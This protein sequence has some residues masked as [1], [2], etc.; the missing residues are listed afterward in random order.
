MNVFNINTSKKFSN[1]KLQL[2]WSTI[3]PWLVERTGHYRIVCEPNKKGSSQIINMLAR[4]ASSEE[5]SEKK[6]KSRVL[7]TTFRLIS[8]DYRIPDVIF[9]GVPDE[10]LVS[11]LLFGPLPDS[12]VQADI[13]PCLE[14]ILY[15]D[16]QVLFESYDYGR[17]QTIHITKD[18]ADEI[19]RLLEKKGLSPDIL[20]NAPAKNKSPWFFAGRVYEDQKV[21]K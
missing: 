1:E 12:S 18:E 13:A 21:R 9:H 15:R 2:C 16:E 19:R 17:F 11:I 4:H 8:K 5:K 10:V 20:V 6:F 3:I 14:I 7:D